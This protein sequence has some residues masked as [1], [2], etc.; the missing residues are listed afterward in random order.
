[1]KL[2]IDYLQY[3]TKD[4]IKIMVAIENGMRNHEWV[5]ITL[6]EK[7]SHLKRGVVHK[8]LRS[9]G[10]Q[11]LIDHTSKPYEAFKLNYLGYDYLALY[12]FLKRGL[13]REIKYKIGCGKESDIYLCEDREGQEMVLKLTRLGRTSFK[14][15]RQNRDYLRNQTHFNWLY[16]SKL[17]SLKEFLFMQA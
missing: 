17:S 3:I 14:S 11:K 16:L 1:M 6:I 5:P 8:I 9:V 7:L 4:E 12:T 10:K 15:V 2:D 13:I